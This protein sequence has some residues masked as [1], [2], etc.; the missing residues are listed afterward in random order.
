MKKHSLLFTLL[1]LFLFF[2]PFRSVE[3]YSGLAPFSINFSRL[4]ICLAILVLF[5]NICIDQKYVNKI[6][7]THNSNPYIPLL[8]IY[9]VFSL[10]YYYVSLSFGKTVLFA[11][12]DFFFRS[13]RG[14]PIGQF[15][16]LLT[17]GIIP[18]YLV[19]KYAEDDSKRK[20]IE[21]TIVLCTLIL[22]YYGYIQLISYFLGLP[23]TGT[24][25]I[26]GVGAQY[27]VGGIGMIRFY[28]LAGEPR[29]FGGFIIVA[30][31]FYAYFCYGKTT[32]FSKINIVLMCVLRRI[33]LR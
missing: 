29:D 4:F 27:G 9:L 1:I 5:A 33:E 23:V 28:S 13:W 22:V 18:Y 8:L 14:R 12:E 21:R 25:F 16:S 24:D 6:F 20:T 11:N 31:L 26:E 19:G 15:V 7:N 32:I 2:L 30:V 3:I 17:Y 10:L